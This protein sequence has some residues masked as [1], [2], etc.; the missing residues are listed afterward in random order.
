MQVNLK[1]LRR[2][3]ENCVLIAP[4]KASL[5]LLQLIKIEGKRSSLVLSV[6]NLDEHYSVS[7]PVKK[8][9]LFTTLVPAE[10]LAKVLRHLKNETLDLDVERSDK[11]EVT[12]IVIKSDMVFKIVVDNNVADFP[13]FPEFRKP[14]PVTV[15]NQKILFEIIKKISFST[16]SSN[17]NKAYS[18]ILFNPNENGLDV[19]TTDIHR[20]SIIKT[21]V[22]ETSVPFILPVEAAKNMMK[23]VSNEAITE[24][25]ISTGAAEKRDDISTPSALTIRIKSENAV[26]FSRLLK[27]EFPN[28]SRVLDLKIIDRS[29]FEIE[30][31]IFSDKLKSICDFHSTQKI[32]SGV[33]DFV[34]DVM[35]VKASG[36]QG[37][38]IE[39]DIKIR[40]VNEDLSMIK[41][42]SL[43]LR[44]LA[45]AISTMGVTVR[46]NMNVGSP[47]QL[48]DINQ[49]YRFYHLVM[50]LRMDHSLVS[51]KKSLTAA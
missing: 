36:E 24:M 44:Y 21:K 48:L 20:L 25:L 16:T 8:G 39:T 4:K 22:A 38:V 28:Y 33:L 17:V 31:K 47:I 7:V 12:K 5:P 34:N 27:N 37:D 43:N 29:W 45:E 11:L 30:K 18:G 40:P 13:A 49:E 3:I 2:A 10:Q 6:T 15:H 51:R 19:V 35:Y 42:C 50:P 23:A 32:V 46:I 26:Y 14:F 1:E 41:I 9:E